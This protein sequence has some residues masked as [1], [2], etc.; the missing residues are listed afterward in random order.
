MTTFTTEDRINAELEPIPFAGFI[1]IL[2]ESIR[3]YRF[4]IWNT[5]DDGD[6]RISEFYTHASYINQYSNL[7]I[8]EDDFKDIVSSDLDSQGRYF[9]KS[10]VGQSD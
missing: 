8:I 2:F 4:K 3:V 1:N 6:I 9:L 10:E 5:E 7:S